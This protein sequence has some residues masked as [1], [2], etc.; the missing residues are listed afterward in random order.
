M[1]QWSKAPSKR[2]LN[3]APFRVGMDAKSGATRDRVHPPTLT[4]VQECGDI[5]LVFAYNLGALKG[6]EEN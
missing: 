1:N 3:G 5:R 2:S 6:M 4:H